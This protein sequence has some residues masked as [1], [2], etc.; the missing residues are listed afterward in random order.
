MGSINNKKSVNK[1]LSNVHFINLINKYS[2]KGPTPRT[3]KRNHI[4]R[5]SGKFYFI[6]KFKF[7]SADVYLH[8]Q[9]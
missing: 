6:Q 8:P 7:P 1:K 3:K 4:I 9:N 5:L 2:Y